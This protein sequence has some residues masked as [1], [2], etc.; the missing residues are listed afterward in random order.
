VSK[1]KSKSL[2]ARDARV[3][4]RALI[5][6]TVMVETK[7]GMVERPIR[8]VIIERTM[9]GAFAWVA[10]ASAGISQATY[11][12]WMRQGEEN[13]ATVD[14]E[15]AER[16]ERGEPRIEY[17]VFGKFYLDVKKAS[18]QAR[19]VNERRVMKDNPLA[20]LRFG[21]GRERPGEPGWTDSNKVEVT[22]KDGAPLNPTTGLQRLDL[23]K[24]TPEQ[25]DQLE[26]LLAIGTTEEGF[27]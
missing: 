4:R 11:F 24:Y 6:S 7:T 14:A 19:L 18:A 12:R 23:S 1:D 17:D 9:T 8:E 13:V 2:T 21:P 10:A 5:D 15:N 25:L 16:D 3:G 22:G 27:K 20:W 26:R